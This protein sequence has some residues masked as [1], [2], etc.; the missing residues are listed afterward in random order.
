MDEILLVDDF[1]PLHDLHKH[2]H[3]LGQGKC[4]ARQLGLVGQQVA[5][6]TVLHHN[7][8]EIVG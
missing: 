2:M 7:D 5:H 3:G 8:D 6:V 1:E 4:F